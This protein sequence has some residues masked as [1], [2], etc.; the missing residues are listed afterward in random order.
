MKTLKFIG[1][2]VLLAWV[3]Y[4]CS[5]DD[6]KGVPI[7]SKIELQGEASKTNITFETSDWKIKNILNTSA[8]NENSQPTA[9]SGNI[10][11]VDGKLIKENTPLTLDN[12]GILEA[13][14][15]DK[16][17]KITRSRDNLIQIEAYENASEEA[18][19]YTIIIEYA[20][21]TQAVIVEQKP[22]EGYIF[23]HIE[24]SISDD[25]GDE[26][27]IQKSISIT[28]EAEAPTTITIIPFDG[29]SPTEI[30][31][32][33]SDDS[34]AFLWFKDGLQEV[35]VPSLIDNGKVISLSTGRYIYGEVT[36]KTISKDVEFEIEIPAGKSSYHTEVE[37]RN[38][39]VSYTLVMQSKSTTHL[40][41]IE[42]KWVEKAITGKY[43][44]VRDY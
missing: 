6:T 22:S 35:N 24:Y 12:L 8:Q 37:W 32:F 14:W 30:S 34:Y 1:L 9:I 18:F 36:E 31:Y 19:N 27:Y 39:Q 29:I 42:G 4:S 17:F 3:C 44:I 43:K 21:K 11:D 13:N 10:Y 16:G 25:D 5:N 38:R 23:K 15:G 40:K 41:T 20:N 33:K 26:L 2:T 7:Q 28:H